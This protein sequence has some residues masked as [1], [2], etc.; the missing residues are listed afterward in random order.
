MPPPSPAHE[1]GDDREY[2]RP[3]QD[4]LDI[5]VDE[6]RVLTSERRRISSLWGE[7]IADVTG[8]CRPGRVS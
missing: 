3:P 7:S 2:R 5:D 6:L 8:G 4:R 1:Q